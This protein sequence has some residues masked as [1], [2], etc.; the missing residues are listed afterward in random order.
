MTVC[1]RKGKSGA[2]AG[3]S[4]LLPLGSALA[5]GSHRS[6]MAGLSAYSGRIVPI[7]TGEK[8]RLLASIDNLDAFLDA[9][10]RRQALPFDGIRAE[11]NTLTFLHAGT[12]YEL[13]NVLP[14][15]FEA[16]ARELS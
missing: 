15:H 16:R 12:T 5:S 3:V 2:L 14:E 9:D 4:A 11:G 6:V 7:A 13:E 8:V 1:V 10:L